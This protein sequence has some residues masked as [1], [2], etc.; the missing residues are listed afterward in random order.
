MTRLLT[1]TLDLVGVLLACLLIGIGS[2]VLVVG[3]ALYG[4][5]VFAVTS[6]YRLTSRERVGESVIGGDRG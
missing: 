5:G 6:A 4:I 1:R 2:L 3:L